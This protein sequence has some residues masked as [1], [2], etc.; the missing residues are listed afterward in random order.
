M[1]LVGNYGG[2]WGNVAG[3]LAQSV[4]L[5]SGLERRNLRGVTNLNV[6]RTIRVRF[7]SAYD[8]ERDELNLVRA[9]V[10]YNI[11]CCGFMAEW[12]RYRFGRVRDENLFRVGITLANIGSFGTQL[13]GQGRVQ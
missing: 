4:Q 13:G 12:G 5:T 1:S 7:E 9:S 8:V 2:G 11:Q 3:S 10:N 6:T